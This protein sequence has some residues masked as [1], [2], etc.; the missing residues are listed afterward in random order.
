MKKSRTYRW[1]VLVMWLGVSQIFLL[2]LF[3]LQTGKQPGKTS[4]IPARLSE[5]QF[6]QITPMF[7][8]G[9]QVFFQ[10]FQ[11]QTTEYWSFHLASGQLKQTQT[12]RWLDDVHPPDQQVIALSSDSKRAVVAVK[13]LDHRWSL[14]LRHANREKEILLQKDVQSAQLSSLTL[15]QWSNDDNYLLFNKEIIF[16]ASDGVPV[17]KLDGTDAVW[18]P[19]A[20]VLLYININGELEW[21]NVETGSKKTLYKKAADQVILG[22]PVWDSSGQYFSFF[23]GRHSHHDRFAEQIHVM[24]GHLY[25]YI[26]REQQDPP[27]Q[28]EHLELSSGG[29]YL[30]YVLNGLLKIV[31]LHTHETRVYDVYTQEQ[32]KRFPL[33]WTDDQGVWFVQNQQILFL[34]ERWKEKQVYQS[35][36]QIIGF[37]P[38]ADHQKIL[39]IE[40]TSQGEKMKLIQMPPLNLQH[41]QQKKEGNKHENRL[42]TS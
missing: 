19:R 16:R 21:L 32:I 17:W 12:P 42:A 40:A 20:P 36:Q 30:T 24:D 33:V 18:S 39:V 23:T 5:F 2:L 7:R 27:A 1:F 31:H 22:P 3:G 10:T 34:D 26:E 38:A 41:A 28:I 6:V 9:E 13:N 29:R 15:I 4:A 25:H 8:Q 35:P 14:Y 11:G 37:Y